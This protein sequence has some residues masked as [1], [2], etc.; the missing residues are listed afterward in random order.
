MIAL[1]I[2]EEKPERRIWCLD[3]DGAVM[4]HLGAMPLIGTFS[5]SD[6]EDFIR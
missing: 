4:M 5:E 6:K 1:R 3:G 2:A